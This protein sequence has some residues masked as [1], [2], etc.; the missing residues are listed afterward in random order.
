MPF[1]E[2]QKAS[3]LTNWIYIMT[4]FV[5]K[6]IRQVKLFCII[7]LYLFFSFWSFK[8]FFMLGHIN[9]SNP[10]FWEGK[11]VQNVDYQLK[12]SCL[13]CKLLNFSPKLRPGALATRLLKYSKMCM[14]LFINLYNT[15]PS[16]SPSFFASVPICVLSST[17][18]SSHFDVCMYCM[19]VFISPS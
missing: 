2:W 8:T 12:A 4:L 9:F 13:L 14:A 5:Y 6:L 7:V 17:Y 3:S 15:F 19:Y 16:L 10:L 11:N 18:G 1:C